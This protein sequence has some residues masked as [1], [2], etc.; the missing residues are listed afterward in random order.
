MNTDDLKRLIKC[1]RKVEERITKWR[2]QLLTPFST[3]DQQL[4]TKLFT[5]RKGKRD[6]FEG[7][8]RTMCRTQMLR[9]PEEMHRLCS[10]AM[11]T[12]EG[13]V[14]ALCVYLGYAEALETI[15]GTHEKQLAA[16]EAA[17]VK[18]RSK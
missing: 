4:I 13:A 9:R 18:E 12:V 7:K 16:L 11:Q 14:A 8:L 10:I 1:E 5:E 6:E 15:R 17:S 2:E 3:T